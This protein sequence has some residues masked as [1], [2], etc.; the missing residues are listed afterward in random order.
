[1]C[2][3]CVW[4]RGGRVSSSQNE[5]TPPS[6]VLSPGLVRREMSNP[7]LE[8]ASECFMLFHHRKDKRFCCRRLTCSSSRCVCVCCGRYLLMLWGQKSVTLRKLSLLLGPKQICSPC[9][10]NLYYNK[11]W[12]VQYNKSLC[13]VKWWKHNLHNPVCV[14]VHLNSYFCG[15]SFRL[16]HG[17]QGFCDIAS[18]RLFSGLRHSLELWMRWATWWIDGA[19]YRASNLRQL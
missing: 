14:C 6:L 12:R 18:E 1:M 4:R 15:N 11:E 19:S 16:D 13:P 3:G 17:S 7:V 2:W 5:T 8:K 10:A 9:S